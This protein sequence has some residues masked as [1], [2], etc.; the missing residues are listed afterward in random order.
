MFEDMFGMFNKDKEEDEE[1]EIIRPERE[2]YS[3]PPVQS[4]AKTFHIIIF[5]NSTFYHN[6]ST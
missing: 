2:T 5:F 4:S 6:I 1:T 3:S